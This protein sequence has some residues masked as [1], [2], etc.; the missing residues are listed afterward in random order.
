MIR[1][2]GPLVFLIA[3]A[4]TGV[5]VGVVGAD[6]AVG[7][8]SDA[9]VDRSLNAT[10]AE[11][12]ETVR[13]TTTAELFEDGPLDYIDE[14][15]PAFEEGEFVSATENGEDILPTL[16]SVEDDGVVAVFN[17]VG[18]STVVI[19]YDVIVPDDADFG[20]THEFDGTA[21]FDDEDV[22]IGG[23]DTLTVGDGPD[24]AEFDVAID[25][26]PASVVAGESIDVEYTIENVGDETATQEITVSADG[27]P[28]KTEEIELAG[29]EATT[30]VT[31]YETGGDDMPDVTIDVESEDDIAT[32]TVDVLEPSSFDVAID[33][34][35][36]S[37]VAGK[38][39]DVEYT[40]ENVGEE[41]ATQ[42]I[43]VSVDGDVIET[44]PVELTGG[45]ATSEVASYE[46]G[47]NDMPEVTIDV[48]SEDDIAT[49]TVDVLE[50]SSFDVEIVAVPDEVVAGEDVTVEVVV[51]NAG[52]E[53][54]TGEIGFAVDDEQVDSEELTLG[55]GENE[56]VTFAYE[57]DGDDVPSLAVSVTS[58]DD[59][60]ESTV[61]VLEPAAFE[62][63]IEEVDEEVVAGENVT[64]EAAVTNAGDE[65]AT[66]EIGFAVDD[67]QQEGVELT[68]AGGESETVT[69]SYETI[70]D[71]IP[72]IAVSVT[73]E[74]DSAESTVEVLEP[75][76]FEVG[77]EEVDEEVVAGENVT[78][79][80]AVTNTGEDGQTQDIAFAVD[81][82]QQE[83]VELTLGAGENETVTFAYETDGDD[84]PSLAVQVTSADDS[85]SATVEVL[86][87]AA[88]DVSIE[89]VADE[90]IAGENVTVEA[91]VSNT[92]DEEETQEI[93]FA[94]DDEQADSAELTLAGGENGTVTFASET[95]EED[96][97]SIAVSVTSED[98]LAESTV[99]VL[100]PAAFG[101]TLEEIPDEVVAGEELT[102][103]VVV[104]NTGEEDATREV[105]FA[106]DNDQADSEELT[107]AGGESETVTFASETAEDDRPTVALNVSTADDSVTGTV[108]VLEPAAFGV[109][110][111]TVD[112][113]V[114][115]GEEIEAE[116]TVTNEGEE[117][118][119]Q[120]VA[121][122]VNG[123][124]QDGEELTLAGGESETVSVEYVT[125]SDDPPSVE[126]AVT[127]ADD[128]AIATVEVL[129]PAAFDVSIEAVAET[130]D[131]GEEITVE[132]VVRNVG[133]VGG[134]RDVAFVVDGDRL[135]GE[136]LTLAGGESEAVTFAYTTSGDDPLEL[137]VE[138]STGDDTATETVQVIGETTFAV[139]ADVRPDAVQAGE[140]VVVA[141]AV[142]NV[143]EEEGTQPVR[144]SADDAE[145]ANEEVTLAGGET[146]ER[147]LEY[148]TATADAPGVSVT[149]T[150]A[151]DT[152]ERTVPV[153]TAASLT[154]VE[155]D[156]AEA[157]V[158]GEVLPVEVTV[159]NDAEAEVTGPFTLVVTAPGGER[160]AAIESTVTVGA[161][162]TEQLTL[163]YPTE[164]EDS[165]AVVL[166]GETAGEVTD[167]VEVRIAEPPE[168]GPFSV[169]VDAADSIAAGADTSV[170]YTVTNTGDAE[171]E[172]TVRFEAD[173]TEL[174]AETVT[175][176][177]DATVQGSFEY[178]TDDDAQSVDL[179]VTAGEDV[180][181][182]TVLV[183]DENGATDDA[184]GDDA[185]DDGAGLGVLAAGLG[186]LALGSY[187]F[188]VRSRPQSG[189]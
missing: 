36:A 144:V 59:S 77:I 10:E 187:Y 16:L 146:V 104:S 147:T 171:G 97:P 24:P 15:T 156:P 106:V 25:S 126:V 70:E 80:A 7:A 11:P 128:S 109:T 119:T 105:R 84:V 125:T 38:S 93:G 123:D 57:T 66:G 48:E 68:L 89:D 145:Q 163:E 54:A 58:E 176:G 44:E 31:S 108:E 174:D 159:G 188:G 3:L 85:A 154:V 12:G 55:A 124:Q 33:S 9:E 168:P 69:F 98:D 114:E 1:S 111:E 161:G 120:S 88:F 139:T 14:F 167:G 86:E 103:E 141:Y 136:E 121:L 127:S 90:V 151:N 2:P 23:D 138:L 172:V 75:A 140:T 82:D 51:T 133:D 73:S 21:Q 74:D 35:P 81:G 153:A 62:V 18:P 130:V 115:A 166:T 6:A 184:P 165:P 47:G 178:V 22:P 113:T 92:G 186:I 49:E 182:T 30:E 110:L 100:E 131:A 112:E 162:E 17:D 63:A 78:V 137:G 52:D 56:T 65:G 95:A 42:E 34:V 185:D 19:T 87:P 149:V 27:D 181:T 60:A 177:A 29:G 91:I 175:V 41:T 45:E 61:E 96:I 94:V 101:V 158:A 5:C 99:D 148:T 107:L 71:D 26:I 129:E 13:V 183:E 116:A 157:V 189:K 132:A 43:T 72:S 122:M 4:L 28:V 160:L 135:D 39:V 53:G 173:G 155:F 164:E 20:E 179:T 152:V 170:E 134:T 150:S 118:A 79:E 46:T 8:A 83:S 37:V 67:D 142:E 32:E 102:V 169:S 50:P 117:M 76:A 40:I 143:G 180:A 64:M